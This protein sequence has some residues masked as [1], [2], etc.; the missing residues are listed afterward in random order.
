MRLHASDEGANK[1]EFNRPVIKTYSVQ[2]LTDLNRNIRQ[3]YK[4]GTQMMLMVPRI[5]SPSVAI[6]VSSSHFICL[7]PLI[8]SSFSF[9]RLMEMSHH[10]GTREQRTSVSLV[11]VE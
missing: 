11:D 2:I 6:T 5:P 10:L 1:Q 4:H 3:N 9:Y 7:P 8:T